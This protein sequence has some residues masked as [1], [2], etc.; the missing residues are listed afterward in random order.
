MGN[1]SRRD[2][3]K[4]GTPVVV[5]PIIASFEGPWWPYNVGV[6]GQKLD[7]TIKLETFQRIYRNIL[8]IIMS[9]TVKIQHVLH[10]TIYLVQRKAVV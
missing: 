7:Q 1:E 2:R 3:L 6:I 10:P 8:G 4:N 5:S 9:Q